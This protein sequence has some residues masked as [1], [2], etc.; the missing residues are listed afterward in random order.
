VANG[1][2]L[3]ELV[4]MGYQF[5]NISADVV[6]LAAGFAR[7]AEAFAQLRSRPVVEH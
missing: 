1:E 2:N 7:V 6:I 3:Q 4:A 5:L